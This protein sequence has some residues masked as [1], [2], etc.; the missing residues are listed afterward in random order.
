MPLHVSLANLNLKLKVQ[1]ESVPK[2]K[3]RQ[4]VNYVMQQNYKH[5]I[6]KDYITIP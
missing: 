1:N 2:K 4:N 6:L 3:I 5:T